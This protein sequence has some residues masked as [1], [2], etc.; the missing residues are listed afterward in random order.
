MVIG[1]DD[2]KIPV[3][4]KNKLTNNSKLD[5]S[6]KGLSVLNDNNKE[7]INQGNTKNDII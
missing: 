5:E 1:D 2:F 6:K 4:N 3:K 7:Y